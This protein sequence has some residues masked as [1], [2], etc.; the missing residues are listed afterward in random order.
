MGHDQATAE[1]RGG[2]IACSNGSWCISVIGV[3]GTWLARRY[4]IKQ[5]LIDHPGE[6]RSHSVATPRG[7]GIAIVISLLVLAAA[8]G[9]A[10][11]TGAA[12]AG[13]RHRAADGGRDW[14]VEA[15][16]G[17]YRPGSALR[18]TWSRRGCSRWSWAI[19]ATRCGWRWRAFVA[20]WY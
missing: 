18:F 11:R 3:A 8:S 14:L 5:S 19:Y 17:R 9:C 16:T 4:A 15:T 20:R 1:L 7:S 10:S 13:V 6:R 12:D 2:L